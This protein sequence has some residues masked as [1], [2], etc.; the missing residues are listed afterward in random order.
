MSIY[1]IK[2]SGLM[3]DWEL[4]K[5]HEQNR[6]NKLKRKVHNEYKRLQILLGAAGSEIK[7]IKKNFWDDV[8][9]NLEDAHE[10]AET[11]ASIRQQSELLSERE[12]RHKHSIEQ[13]KL[14]NRLEK[15][16]YF[17]RIDFIEAEEKSVEQIYI[18]VGS[19]YDEE[20]SSFLVYDWRA[21][22]SSVYYDYSVGPAKYEAP[23]GIIAGT[24]E[25]K[26][27]FVIRN[28]EI[29]SMFD[30]GITI[31]DE[32]LQKV[33][34]KQ[35][36]SQMKSIVATIQKEQN[37]I[38]RNTKSRLLIV[39]G[40]AGSGKT[41]AALQRAAYLLYRFRDQLSSEQLLL[42]SPNPLFNSYVAS[43][44]PELGEANMQQTTFQQ[45]LNQRLGDF[46][47]IEDLFLQMEYVLSS[48]DDEEYE[49]R[50]EGIR[51]KS[52]RNFLQEIDSL[53][54]NLKKAGMIFKPI[55]FRREKILSAEEIYHYFYQLGDELSLPARMNLTVDKIRKE[56]RKRELEERKKPWVEE[57]MQYLDKGEYLKSYRKALKNE[58]HEFNGIDSETQYL[59]SAIVK[60]RFKS[61][62]RKINEFAFVDTESIYRTLFEVEQKKELNHWE[63][64]CKQSIHEMDQGRLFYEDATPY[65]YLK[66][67][68]EGFKVNTRVRYL[69]IDEAQ[70]YSSF[71]FA[72]L[73][74]LFPQS[75]MT[76]L[77]DPNQ[78]IVAHGE[79]AGGTDI[80]TSLFTEAETE[81][82][83]LK[84]S[85]R[86]TKEIVEFTREVVKDGGSIEP[87]NRP[88]Q[89]PV[90]FTV[91][92]EQQYLLCLEKTIYHL[93]GLGFQNIALIGKTAAESE[94]VYKE[95]KSKMEIKLVKKGKSEFE[96]GLLVIP[97]YL[98]K[99]IEFDAV[100]ILNA[101][102]DRYYLERERNLFYTSCTRAM[103]ELCLV[104]I[105][106]VSPFISGV[107]KDLF[108]GVKWC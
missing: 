46:F 69:F 8:T 82:V 12:R 75:K 41:S 31:G 19:F 107:S 77:G 102:K 50:L 36:D 79:M 21:P 108:T 104:S 105:G 54:N 84:R 10:A 47:D 67:Q 22:I 28:G 95:L 88:G 44:L 78:T 55:Y 90:V 93:Q 32:L 65:L 5:I 17:G 94:G 83:V 35:A 62:Y 89:K 76:I 100:I 34:G 86:S 51:Y 13:V 16:P 74:K 71:Q 45:Y 25:L 56:V 80:L 64:V 103:H 98:A 2:R 40:A 61:L 97:T 63:R 15:T 23:E 27:Q 52:S 37:T 99:G 9:V 60:K 96:D 59:A 14:L 68:L 29:I 33:L 26:R 66:D 57:E 6:V 39:H 42:F 81:K 106:E 73:A 38:I 87:F 49:A 1:F 72:F 18:G 92:D 53:L 11:H 43:V 91:K 85:Y 20:S 58:E 101:S 7:S 3:A 24:L 30:T 70:D 48:I 4:E